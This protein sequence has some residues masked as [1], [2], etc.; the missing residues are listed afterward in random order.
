MDETERKMIALISISPF[1]ANDEIARALGDVSEATVSRRLT[2]LRQRRWIG[3]RVNFP[4]AE[5]LSERLLVFLKLNPQE[6]ASQEH[7][8]ATE[9]EFAQFLSERLFEASPFDSF[10]GKVVVTGVSGVA[11][12]DADL[13]LEVCADESASWNAFVFELRKLDGVIST[14]TMQVFPIFQRHESSDPPPRHERN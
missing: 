11:G 5:G 12:K 8:Y 4:E 7:G 9:G 13:L 3:F 2:S 14:E 1:V 10:R 6:V